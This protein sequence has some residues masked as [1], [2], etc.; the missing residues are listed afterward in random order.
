MSSKLFLNG[1]VYMSG[2]E[3]PVRGHY[4]DEIREAEEVAH[5]Y[6]RPLPKA[7]EDFW[8]GPCNLR[9][10][11]VDNVDDSWITLPDLLKISGRD[12]NWI[13]DQVIDGKFDIA[14]RRGTKVPLFRFKNLTTLATAEEPQKTTRKDNT[15]KRSWFKS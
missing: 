2:Y 9:Y 14:V 8:D 10:R 1:R 12:E 7:P 5:K 4:D 15:K 11:V 13:T 3:Q 6:L